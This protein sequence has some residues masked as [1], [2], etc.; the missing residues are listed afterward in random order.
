M[1]AVEQHRAVIDAA[2]TAGVTFVAY[3]SVLHCDTSPLVLA[4]APK[5]YR[6]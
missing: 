2:K 3:T 4:K 5:L 6:D 1:S